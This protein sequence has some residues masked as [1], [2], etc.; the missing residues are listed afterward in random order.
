M[1]GRGSSPDPKLPEG[2]PNRAATDPRA[3]PVS[4]QYASIIGPD[5]AVVGEVRA[6]KLVIGHLSDREAEV[7]LVHLDG[8]PPEPL[9]AAPRDSRLI[10]DGTG[11]ARARLDP[12]A[13]R[14]LSVESPGPLLSLRA[15][16]DDHRFE[17]DLVFQADQAERLIAAGRAGDREALVRLAMLRCDTARLTGRRIKEQRAAVRRLLMLADERLD[18]HLRAAHLAWEERRWT[19]ALEHLEVPRAPEDETPIHQVARLRT[20]LLLQLGRHE[21]AQ[22]AAQGLDPRRT[23]DRELLQ[24]TA[25]LGGS[26]EPTAPEARSLALHQQAEG[27]EPERAAAL[28]D[29]PE[30]WQTQSCGALAPLVEAWLAW[31]PEAPRAA[32]RRTLGLRYFLALE[33]PWATLHAL[34]MDEHELQSLRARVRAALQ[35]ESP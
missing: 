5:L 17:L 23:A 1:F 11:R 2:A 32:A 25:A 9:A 35:G 20:L 24:L 29:Q 33:A 19:V 27:L 26:V 22:E 31:S 21:A 18:A 30:L 15:Q 14:P 13:V 8:R 10:C 7:A 6:W 16:F 28:L 34:A 3:T 4:A 12:D